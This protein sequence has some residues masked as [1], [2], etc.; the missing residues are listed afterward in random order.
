MLIMI[1]VAYISVGTTHSIL[2]PSFVFRCLLCGCI[3]ALLELYGNQIGE[4][5]HI[6]SYHEYFKYELRYLKFFAKVCE[7]FYSLDFGHAGETFLPI[8][9][10]S[11]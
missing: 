11:Y 8:C 7:G 3:K 10:F 1:I 4:R 6:V 9:F 2:V 5:C